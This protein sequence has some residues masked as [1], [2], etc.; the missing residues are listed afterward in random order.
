M[1]DATLAQVAEFMGYK[2][3]AENPSDSLAQFRK[4]WATM[5]D[6]DKAQLKAGIGDGTLTY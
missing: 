1:A 4:D 3:G 5:S 2:N 6:T